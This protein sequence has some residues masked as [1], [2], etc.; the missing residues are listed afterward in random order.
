MG[1]ESGPTNSRVKFSGIEAQLRTEPFRFEFFQA[2]RLLQKLLPHKAR[3][4]SYARP[5]DEAMRFGTNPALG[6]PASDI[7]SIDWSNAEQPR[8]MVNFMGLTGPSGVLPLAYSELVLERLR[9]RDGGMAAFFD[10]FNHRMIAFFYAAW[11]KY[12]LPPAGGLDNGKAIRQLGALIGIGSE[13]LS[14]RQPLPDDALLFYSGSLALRA[15]PPGAL[16]DILTDYFGVTVELEQFVGAWYKLESSSL[17]RFE[18]DGGYT[19]QLG[20][21]TV[22]GDEIWSIQARA[23]I[24]LG[25][26][27]R[28]Q[29]EQFLPTGPAFAALRGRARFFCGTEIDF[30]VQLILDRSDVPVCAL[31]ENQPPQLG[32]L[33][34]MKSSADFD[35]DPSDTVFVLN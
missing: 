23:R 18:G 6:F 35:R 13:G 24:R 30:E 5:G 4:G 29:Y 32:W 8:M 10:I 1:A 14:G 26:L 25:P 7:Q 9:A 12:R 20:V 33:T 3:I 27:S 2:V 21:G 19:E 17:C 22:A 34:W 16:R 31:D 15:R 11:E 28:K